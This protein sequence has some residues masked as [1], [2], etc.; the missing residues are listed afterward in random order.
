MGEI[1][2]SPREP[3]IVS[4][5]AVDMLKRVGI[6]LCGGASVGYPAIAG[7]IEANPHR[8]CPVHYVVLIAD[9]A[10]SG[11][12]K[13]DVSTRFPS[14]YVLAKYF[15]DHMKSRHPDIMRSLA[16]LFARQEER[17]TK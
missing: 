17:D 14:A 8:V 9:A 13:D 11:V 4:A 6:V 1:T 2:T 15:V 3:A 7:W 5:S 12:S 16:I 10:A